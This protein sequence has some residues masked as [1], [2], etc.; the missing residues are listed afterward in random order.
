[1]EAW[2]LLRRIKV[3]L[4]LSETI[5]RPWSVVNQRI[6]PMLEVHP[7]IR[8]R[9]LTKTENLSAQVVGLLKA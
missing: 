5:G 7:L 9:M 3:Q 2:D 4:T 8:S 6:A 1:M